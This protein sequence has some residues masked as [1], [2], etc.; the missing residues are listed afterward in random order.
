[1][2][3]LT[4]TT[5]A[6]RGS[7]GLQVKAAP[8]MR[9]K[10]LGPVQP[11]VHLQTPSRHVPPPGEELGD[12]FGMKPNKKISHFYIGLVKKGGDLQV[13]SLICTGSIQFGIRGRLYIKCWGVIG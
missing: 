11:L 1:V 6:S 4:H 2:P 8:A 13:F 9:A 3:S 10:Q 7:S 12:D 5:V